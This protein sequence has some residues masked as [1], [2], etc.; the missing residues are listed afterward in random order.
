MSIEKLWNLL[1]CNR[2]EYIIYYVQMVGFNNLSKMF[3][4]LLYCISLRYYDGC[5]TIYDTIQNSELHRVR[6]LLIKDA[7]FVFYIINS[8]QDLVQAKIKN[9]T[10]NNQLRQ[11]IQE[12][13]PQWLRGFSLVIIERVYNQKALFI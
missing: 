13:N 9:M 10:L 5:N 4:T 7:W 6:N 11:L 8:V 1:N 12:I 2:I 3:L